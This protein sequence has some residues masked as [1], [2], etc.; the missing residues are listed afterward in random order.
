MLCISFF[1]WRGEMRID[2][3]TLGVSGGACRVEP[4][5]MLGLAMGGPAG[6]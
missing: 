6:I 3:V 2:C 1:R 5:G 4:A